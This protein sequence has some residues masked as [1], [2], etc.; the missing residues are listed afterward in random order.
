MSNRR[1]RL[2]FVLSGAGVLGRALRFLD[3]LVRWWLLDFG[4]IVL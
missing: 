4:Q 2:A 3:V 1:T